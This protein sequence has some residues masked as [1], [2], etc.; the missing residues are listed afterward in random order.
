MSTFKM[1]ESMRGEV[2]ASLPWLAASVPVSIVTG[3]LGGALQAREWFGVFNA[4]NVANATV[5]QLAPLAVAFCH[6]PDLAWL[7]PA[8]LV[9]RAVGAIPT[10][11]VLARALPLG[12]GGGFDSSRLKALF[13]YGGWISVTNVMGPLLSTMDR[14]MI[15]SLFSAEAVAFYTV[16]FNLVSRA[17]VIPGALTASLFP[18]LS[19]SSQEHSAQ[20]ASDAVAALAAVMTP[21]FVL[22]IA[23][24]PVFMRHWVGAGFA[25]HAAPLGIILLVGVWVNGLA[26]VPYGQLQASGRPDIPAKF[27]AAELIPFL[28]ILWL[29]LHYFG[30]VGAAYAWSLRVA[31]DALLL[32]RAGGRIP[33]WHRLIPGGLMVILAGCSAPTFVLS[34]KTAYELGLLVAASIWS[35]H[36]S[37]AIRSVVRGRLKVPSIRSAV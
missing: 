17:S 20:L 22:T 24:L 37:P 1:P 29:G 4:I 36:L 26:Y 28:G 16:P 12:A 10:F 35:W 25:G 5:S 19:R 8:V 7:I 30:L 33:R 31:V 14:M 13:S 27:H 6:G 21:I 34:V 3:V 11:I 23:A 2:M 15:G 9:T 32:F 18:K